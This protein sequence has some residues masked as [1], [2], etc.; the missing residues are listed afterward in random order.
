[1]HARTPSPFVCDTMAAETMRSPDAM[2]VRL[3]VPPLSPPHT[4]PSTGTQAIALLDTLD[5]DVNTF[6]MRVREWYS[7]HFPELVKIVNDNYQYAKVRGARTRAAGREHVGTRAAGRSSW[8]GRQLAEL[9]R[10]LMGACSHNVSPALRLQLT[11]LIKDKGTLG[12]DKLEELKEVVGEEDKAKEIIEVR[13][14]GHVGWRGTVCMSC[15]A[16][17]VMCLGRM[18]RVVQVQQTFRRCCPAARPQAAKHSM[19][20]DISPIDLI[21]IETFAR[22]VISLA[23]YRQKL[24]TYL[25]GAWGSRRGGG[26]EACRV[27]AA[28]ATHARCPSSTA[29]TS[30]HPVLTRPCAGAPAAYVCACRQDGRS[31]PQPG[32]AH[33]RPRGR[34]PHIPRRLADQPGQVPRLHGADPGR[35]EGA[36][37]V[38]RRV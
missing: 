9:W 3:Y 38:R 11:L 30:S 33:W 19:G 10:L 22:R 34:A 13:R 26:G 25:A 32:G 29:P 31:G 18:K 17:C 5:K 2:S 23:E 1:M 20:Q 4:H 21:N 24:S 28:V 27:L 12:E 7:W 37:Q 6:V 14:W 36:V 16:H 15:V 8:L 35:G